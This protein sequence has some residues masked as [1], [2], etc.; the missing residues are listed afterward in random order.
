MHKIFVFD[1]SAPF[2]WDFLPLYTLQMT[3]RVTI[4]K[5]SHFSFQEICWFLD[6]G[7]DDCLHIVRD[8]RIIKGIEVN[9]KP[10]AFEM[11]ESERSLELI[12]SSNDPDS[13]KKTIAFT[14]EWLDLDRDMSSFYQLDHAFALELQRKYFGLRMVRIPD[15]FEA[16]CW[17]IIG[18]Q[19]N[20]SFA[21]RLKRSFVELYG[22]Q[23]EW[24][25]KKLH[26]F[27]EPAVVSKVN[28][29][30]LRALQFSRQKAE[31]IIFLAQRFDSGDLHIDMILRHEDT[32]SMSAELQRL[33]GVGEWTANYV[34]MKTFGRMDSVP[35]GDAGLI[36]GIRQSLNLSAKPTRTE[37]QEVLAGAQG[38]EAY[39]VYF[40]WRSLSEPPTSVSQP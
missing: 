2:S 9:G 32:A 8:E 38:W 18:Q 34:L 20:L 21:Y 36:N 33:R 29:A 31:Y 30:D 6:R 39:L 19:I 4:P 26:L 23:M 5:P 7:Y 28:V 27:P 16:L 24:M 14:K 17:S 13:V 12:V 22:G 1:S 3:T 37:V 15:F 10:V 25:G 11:A 40:I 35:Y